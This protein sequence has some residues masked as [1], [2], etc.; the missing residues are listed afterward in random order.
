MVRGSGGV[1]RDDVA[2]CCED[3]DKDISKFINRPAVC[4]GAVAARGGVGQEVEPFVDDS[5]LLRGV[6][7]AGYGVLRELWDGIGPRLE[8]LSE[9]F[10]EGGVPADV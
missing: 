1:L 9:I 10:F 8:F 2:S 5:T 3:G 4:D 6:P 7:P